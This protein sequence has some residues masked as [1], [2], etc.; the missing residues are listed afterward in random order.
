VSKEGARRCPWL[1]LQIAPNSAPL[2]K[3]GNGSSSPTRNR[4]RTNMSD[5]HELIAELEAEIEHLRDAAERC[6]KIDLGTK[7]AIAL[8]VASLAAAVLWFKPVTLMLGIALALGGFALHGSNRSTLDEVVGR[9]AA[10]EARRASLIDGLQLQTLEH[11]EARDEVERRSPGSALVAAA[12]GLAVDRHPLRP[13]GPG[14]AHKGREGGL[15]Q[16]R[17]D[18]VHQEG[19]PAR[20][21]TP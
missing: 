19:Q 13:A 11:Q 10:V 1:R 18:P 8:G 5:P 14:L 2:R 9:I 16:I 20:P 21:G 17:I 12:R 15:E 7:L 6:R 4:S 3:L